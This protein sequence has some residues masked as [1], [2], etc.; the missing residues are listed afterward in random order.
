MKRREDEI[1]EIIHDNPL[2]SQKDIASKLDIT[3]SS[4][5][6]HINNLTKKGKIIGRGYVLSKADKVCVIGGTNIDFFGRPDDELIEG[7]SN[8]GDIKISIGGS[9]R[10][11]A[12]NLVRLGIETELITAI[13]KDQYGEIIKER[14]LKSGLRIAKNNFYDSKTTS[15]YLALLN[16]KGDVCYTVSEMSIMDLVTPSV[17]AQKK[18]DIEH[19]EL[20]IIDTNLPQE[21]IE[22]IASN[23]SHKKILAYPDSIHKA[24][25]LNKVWHSLHY[26]QPNY[27]ELQAMTNNQIK[28][29]KDVVKAVN[30]LIEGGIK[31]VLVTMGF[32]G[33]YF[34]SKDIRFFVS[35]PEVDIVEQMGWREAYFA[36]IAYGLYHDKTEKESIDIGRYASTIALESYE[37]I[38]PW[39]NITEIEDRIRT[40]E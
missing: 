21:T 7:D 4:V 3:R 28:D 11:I 29:A 35:A 8:T 16:H 17:I 20:I 2:I 10:N 13:G 38:S 40:N 5:G 26:V 12:E 6:V 39:L 27:G 24:K 14:S 30:I 23:F 32:K 37:T 34:A 18:A 19:S 9:A 25:K 22:Y 1:L 36:G 15:T 31:N 33:A